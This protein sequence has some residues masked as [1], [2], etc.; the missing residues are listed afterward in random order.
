MSVEIKTLTIDDWPILEKL[1]DNEDI[2]R[3]AQTK[4]EIPKEEYKSYTHNSFLNPKEHIYAFITDNEIVSIT[5]V[6]DF[7]SLPGYLVKNFKHFKKSNLYNPVINGLAPTLNKIIEIQEQKG[8]YTFWMAK[9]GNYKRLNQERTRHLMF[10][11][12][13]PILQN[14]EIT[15]EEYLPKNTKSKYRFHSEGIYFGK[16][17]TEDTCVIRYTCKQQY[18]TNVN[19]NLSQKMFNK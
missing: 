11:V 12:G 3:I 13:C 8:L 1:I 18:R 14:Y 16:V 2:F 7:E 4:M 15:I 10:N 17:L 19:L 9:T 5:T 6:L